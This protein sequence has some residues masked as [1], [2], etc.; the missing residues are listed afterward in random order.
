MK[1]LFSMKGRINRQK[2]FVT[3][4]IIAIVAYAVAFMLGF[5]MGMTGS[6]SSAAGTLGFVV[7][8]AA[9]VVQGF[10]VVKRLHD[11]NKPSRQYW[12]LCIPLY[13]IYLGLVLL[14]VKGTAGTNQYGDDPLAA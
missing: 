11:L 9:A 5:A 13:N 4:L 10:L 2:Y 7:G 8:I 1:D 6:N 12:L 3:S 14:F